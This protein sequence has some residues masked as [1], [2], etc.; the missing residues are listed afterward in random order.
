[1]SESKPRSSGKSHRRPSGSQK[2]QRT[3]QAIGVYDDREWARFQVSLER[4]RKSAAADE[5]GESVAAFVRWQTIGR[6][7]RKLPPRR[8]NS[9]LSPET[10][11]Q[12]GEIMTELLR[13]GNNLNQ[14]ARH[15]NAGDDLPTETLVAT[16]NEHRETL[17]ALRRLAGIED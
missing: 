11:A 13:Q 5:Y 4:Y 17:R 10:V 16:L 7:V 12:L 8:T 3:H 1:M 14:M 9:D 15:L 6:G 2:R